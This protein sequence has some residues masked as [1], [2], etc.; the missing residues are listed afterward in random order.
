MVDR[1]LQIALRTLLTKTK[2]FKVCGELQ[3]ARMPEVGI[4]SCPLVFKV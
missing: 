2:S 3:Y 4:I 1:A